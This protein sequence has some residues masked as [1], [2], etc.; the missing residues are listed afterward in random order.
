MNQTKPCTSAIPKLWGVPPIGGHGRDPG[1]PP[2]RGWGG[3][4]TQLRSR[5]GPR[6]PARGS[7]PGSRQGPRLP[8][9]AGDLLPRPSAALAPGGGEGTADR[10]KGGPLL[11]LME[12]ASRPG[13]RRPRQFQLPCRAAVSPQGR[14][15]AAWPS[16]ALYS[17]APAP[18]APGRAE[19]PRPAAR[20]GRGPRERCRRPPTSRRRGLLPGP[21]ACASQEAGQRGAAGLR[22]RDGQRQEVGPAAGG[23]GPARPAGGALARGP[24]PAE[25]PAARAAEGRRPRTWLGS[26]AAPLAGR[27]AG[28]LTPVRRAWALAPLAAAGAATPLA[29]GETAGPVLGAGPSPLRNTGRVIPIQGQ[30]SGVTADAGQK[31]S[32]PQCSDCACPLAGDRLVARPG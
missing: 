16:A 8:A 25:C 21:A 18:T 26:G 3:S 9:V 22:Y 28:S 7:T 13:V 23:R 24:L 15:A 11:Y 5:P 6:L 14:A 29:R 32:R 2:H 30:A 20:G 17:W 12:A 19:A 27:L 1:Q 31:P 10:D 4:A